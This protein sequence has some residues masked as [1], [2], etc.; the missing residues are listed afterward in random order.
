MLNVLPTSVQGFLLEW[1]RLVHP[2]KQVQHN[3]A[4][5]QTWGKHGYV[6]KGNKN[7]RGHGQKRKLKI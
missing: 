7:G 3:A 5:I 6:S 1:F 2:L 4:R